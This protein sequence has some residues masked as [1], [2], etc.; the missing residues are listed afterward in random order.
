MKIHNLTCPSCGGTLDINIDKCKQI[1]CPYC[2]QRFLVDDE[3]TYVEINKNININKTER[4]IDEAEIIR[5]QNIEKL[6]KIRAE[7]KFTKTAFRFLWFIMSMLF[8]LVMISVIKDVYDKS[9]R[10]EPY[11]KTSSSSFSYQWDNYIEVVDSFEN[12]GFLNITT[13]DLDDASLF[14]KENTVSKVTIDGK[15]SFSE[16]DEFPESA[17]VVIYYH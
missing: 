10:K 5:A 12:A 14:K 9:G 7:A 11:I 16:G 15:E 8:V 6:A 1:F 17:E 13:V 3:K 4:K 2:G